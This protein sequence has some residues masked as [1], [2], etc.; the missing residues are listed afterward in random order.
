MHMQSTEKEY[1]V[2]WLLSHYGTYH[3]YLYVWWFPKTGWKLS[4][5]SIPLLSAWLPISMWL[6]VNLFLNYYF[7]SN[8]ILEYFTL[9]IV[10]FLLWLFLPLIIISSV[11]IFYYVFFSSMTNL[12]SL[13]KNIFSNLFFTAT[14]YKLMCWISAI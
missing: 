6:T 1:I 14:K 11:I 2:K 10:I 3:I 13:S 9:F 12:Y 8:T 7:F 4:S 5:I